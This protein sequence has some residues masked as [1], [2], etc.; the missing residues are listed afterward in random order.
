MVCIP[1]RAY[2]RKLVIGSGINHQF[3]SPKLSF[4]TCRCESNFFRTIIAQ[5]GEDV[6]PL[7][8]KPV[9]P[10][11]SV[12]NTDNSRTVR[13]YRLP[14]TGIQFLG[15]LFVERVKSGLEVVKRICD[16]LLCVGGPACHENDD[17]KRR[18]G[19]ECETRIVSQEFTHCESHVI[20]VII[21]RG[22]TDIHFW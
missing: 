3:N 17:P 20:N 15:T 19:V 11:G 1:S 8:G 14:G 6:A 22:E 13:P 4:P 12:C 5:N 18:H 16:D 21:A 9:H 10:Q 2:E 7:E